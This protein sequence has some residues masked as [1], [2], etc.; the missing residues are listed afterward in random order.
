MKVVHVPFCTG[1]PFPAD[2]IW[3]P[4]RPSEV[5]PLLIEFKKDVTR[6]WHTPSLRIY[7]QVGIGVFIAYTWKAS[8]RE[9]AELREHLDHC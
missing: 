7:E 6:G 3:L 1:D 2:A 4:L 9:L 8:Q 5:E